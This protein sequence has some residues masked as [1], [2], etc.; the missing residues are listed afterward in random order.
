MKK[1]ILQLV[2]A[3][4]FTTTLFFSTGH[5]TY[6]QPVIGFTSFISSGLSSPVDIANAGDGTNRLFIVEQGGRIRIHNGTTLLTT[7]F[8][9]ISTI[10]SAGGERGLLSVAFHPDYENPL[11]RYFFVYYTNTSGDI[12]IARYQAQALNPNEADAASGVVLL[13]IPK[14]FS[15]HNGGDLNFGPDGYLYFGTGDG[16]SGGDPNNFAQN[17]L[18]LLGKMI[19][20]DVNNFLTPPYYTIPA[21]NPYV[22]DPTVDDRI[23]SIGLRNPWKWSF[24]R[25]TNDMWI[26]DVGQGSW[27]EV[28]F[29]SNGNTGGINYGWRCYEGT[30]SYNPT[31]CLPQSSYISP[32]FQYAHDFATGGFSITGGNVYRGA[33]FPALQ[34]YYICADYVSGNVWLINSNGAGGWITRR[35]AGLPG[36]ISA[37]GEAEN[38]TMYAVSLGGSVYKIEVTTVLPLSLVSFSGKKETG[39]NQLHWNTVNE[40]NVNRFIIEYSTTGINFITVGELPALNQTNNQTYGF[41]HTTNETGKVFYRLR[42]ENNNGSA[43]YSSII[44]IDR[45][46]SGPV[47]V[48]PTVVRNNQLQVVSENAL[49]AIQILNTNGQLLLNKQTGGQTGYFTIVIPPVSKGMYFVQVQTATGNET[50]KIII[51]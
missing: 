29:R 7:P 20:I 1:N 5:F 51:E 48:F 39:F 43:N 41:R 44:S 12:T 31:G 10:I 21:D 16:G 36:N 34:G 19:R 47:K 9:D 40:Q 14:P 35:Q 13:N 30:A 27:E 11:N 42:I 8:L 49:T 25:N 3:T 32:I 45:K 38:G 2:Q 23:W 46:A 15:N 37:F 6:A 17:G 28:N 24:D 4:L 18:S 33:E 26:A 22:T 50:V